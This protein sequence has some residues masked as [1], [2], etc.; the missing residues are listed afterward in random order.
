ML[1]D[2]RLICLSCALVTAACCAFWLWPG[3]GKATGERSALDSSFFTPP[4]GDVDAWPNL[5]GPYHNSVSAE[6]GLRTEWPAAG[7]P[8]L[9]RIDVGRGYSSPVAMDSRLVLLHR[10]GDTERIESFDADT[11]ASQWRFDYPTSYTCRYEYSDGPYSTPILDD[12]RIYAVGAQGQ[13]HC[14]DLATG[15]LVWRRNPHEDYHVPEALFPVGASPLL[16]GELLIFN[17]GSRA[18]GAGIIALDKHSG[19]TVWT[20]TDHGASYATPRAATIHGR[21]IVLVVTFE[22]LVALDPRSGRVHWSVPFRPHSPDSVNAAS[23]VVAGDLVLMVTGPGPGGICLRVLPD[24][25]YEEAWR[26]RRN[27]DSQFNTLVDTDGYVYGYSSKRIRASFRCVDL[28]TGELRWQW[29]SPLERGSAIAA[30]GR[31][32]LWGEH[33]HLASVDINPNEV[34]PRS[35]TADPLLAAPCYASPALYRGKLYLRNDETLLCLDL[36]SSRGPAR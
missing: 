18:D 27:L 3:A 35:M 1:R 17:L 11:G 24:G 25:R 22:G 9:W 19:E 20:A 21:R 4:G 28:Q 29:R 7:P 31:F 32:I 16:E 36:R 15:Q 12:G 14:L 2:N 33:G 5:F 34:V 10:M 26:E 6:T 8:E 23:P 30:D 13:F